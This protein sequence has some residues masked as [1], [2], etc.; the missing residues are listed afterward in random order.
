[1]YDVHLLWHKRLVLL[2]GKME[3]QHVVVPV[4]MTEDPVKTNQNVA[5]SV[6]VH[7]Q[8]P[9]GRSQTLKARTK[10]QGKN[11]GYH[12]AKKRHTMIHTQRSS[13]S[14]PPHKIESSSFSTQHS[15]QTMTDQKKGVV[16]LKNLGLTCYANATLQCL[17]HIERVPWVFTEGRYNT[18]F[19]K[20]ATGKRL[21]QQNVSKLFADVVSQQE[22]GSAPGVLRPG[23]FWTAMKESIRGSAVYG[24]FA[25]TAPHDAHEFLM[26]MLETLHT[27]VSISVDMQ[28]MKS[29]PVTDTEKRVVEALEVWKNE[30]SKEYSPLVDLFHG[31]L[32]RRTRC[33]T[34]NTVSHRWET[35]NTIKGAV[36]Q[37]SAENDASPVDLLSMLKEDLKGEDI[38]GYSCDKCSPTRTVAHR[39]TAIWRLP[40]T[41]IICLKRFTYDGRKIHTRIKMPTCEPFNLKELFSD[42]SPEKDAVTEY[43]LRAIVDHHGGSGGGHYTAQCKHKVTDAWHIY[44]DENTHLVQTPIVG[45]TTYISFWERV[46]TK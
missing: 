46:A 10:E 40:Q 38:E 26:Y 13:S 11:Y 39:D 36:P 3:E 44:D 7:T 41:L 15:S 21:L 9:A 19:K 42:E 31:L 45:D 37:R 32:H 25:Q 18:L 24:H 4:D 22:N 28:I 12:L 16:G 29:P 34:C 20:D 5:V 33:L 27:S 2:L 6:S 14:I 17:R 23:G 1:M 43:T 8:A 30:F 35:F